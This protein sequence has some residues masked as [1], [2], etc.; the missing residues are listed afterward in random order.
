M[1]A[2]PCSTGNILTVAWKLAPE[3]SLHLGDLL[4]W[5]KARDSPGLLSTQALEFMF[6]G[7]PPGNYGAGWL[8]ETSPRRKAYHEGGDPGF[9]AFEARYPD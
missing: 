3:E 2:A 5:N 1:R 9:A 7:H 6:T 8:I 4:R